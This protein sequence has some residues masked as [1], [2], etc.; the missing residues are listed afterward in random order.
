[1]EVADFFLLKHL[2]R[3]VVLAEMQEVKT[4]MQLPEL[5]Q[6]MALE[7]VQMQTD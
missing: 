5:S 1:M 2:S 4:A 7:S 6:M 3:E